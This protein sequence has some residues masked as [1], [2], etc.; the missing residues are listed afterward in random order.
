MPNFL[1]VSAKLYFELRRIL[2]RPAALCAGGRNIEK[3]QDSHFRAV[4][5][6]R[7]VLKAVGPRGSAGAARGHPRRDAMITGNDRR[8]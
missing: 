2:F 4:D 7:E 8:R 3:R 6:L 1:A 5:N